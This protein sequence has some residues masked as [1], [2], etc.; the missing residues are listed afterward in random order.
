MALPLVFELSWLEAFLDNKPEQ[1]KNILKK[2]WEFYMAKE[3]IIESLLNLIIDK[4][5]NPIM[6]DV[7]ELPDDVL[8]AIAPKE[9]TPEIV[10]TREQL[11]AGTVVYLVMRGIKFD[12]KF[13][14][15]TKEEMQEGA[16]IFIYLTLLEKEKREGII[17]DYHVSG[18]PFNPKSKLY[19]K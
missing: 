18:D 2:R 10:M 11:N 16:K 17:S 3:H 5:F 7:S 9:A 4:K 8:Y 12:T 1:A 15:T 13:I 14:E 19:I 6:L